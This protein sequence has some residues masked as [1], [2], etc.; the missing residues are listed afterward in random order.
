MEYGLIGEHLSHS[1]SKKIHESLAEYRYDL[2]EIQ[3]YDLKSFFEKKEFKAINVTIPYKE[4]VIPFLD[5]ISKQAKEIGAVNVVVNKNGKLIGHNTDYDG[6]ELLSQHAKINFENKNV[7]ILGSGGASKACKA[8]IKNHN[9]K[10]I[11]RAS[12]KNKVDCISYDEIK[13]HQEIEIIVNTTPVGMYPDNEKSLVD[14]DCFPNLEGYLDV[15]YNPIN[16]IQALKAKEKGI[17]SEGGLYMLVAQAIKSIE[18]FLGKRIDE[19]LIKHLYKKTLQENSNIVLIG[20][21]SSGK[22]SI[23]KQLASKLN[24]QFSDTDDLIMKKYKLTPNEIIISKGEKYFREA[25]AKRMKTR[26]NVEHSPDEEIFSLIGSKEG[27]ANFIRLLINPTTVEK[28]RDIILVP[29]PGYA[30]YKEMIKVSGGCA[31]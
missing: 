26:F 2:Y 11:L 19:T 29:D 7:L 21:P 17:K 14:L 25:I 1:F 16:T 18:I 27:I 3:P 22:T 24:I 20:M 28:D 31:Y 8:V 9:V 13:K 23:G 4:K 12:R 10:N 15:I 6:F 30:S 5:E